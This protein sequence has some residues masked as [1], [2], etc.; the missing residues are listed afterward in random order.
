MAT[1]SKP[2]YIIVGKAVH[3]I[4]KHHAEEVMIGSSLVPMKATRFMDCKILVDEEAD[5]LYIGVGGDQG[6]F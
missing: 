1:F 4:F 3:D 6:E 5:P 2:D